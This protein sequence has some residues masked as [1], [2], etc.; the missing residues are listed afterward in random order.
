MSSILEDATLTDHDYRDAARQLF[1]AKKVEGFLPVGLHLYR[2]ADG[3]ILYARVRMH[4]PAADGGHEKLIRPFWHNGTRWTHGEP[5]QD[6][7]KL[8]YGLPDL[9]AHG[10]AVAVIVE[11]EQKADALTKIG[12]G[13]FIGITSGGATSAGGAE[14]SPLAGRHVL[15][16]P[17]HDAPGAK[18][19]DE[20]AE[21]LGEQ[22][23][24]VEQLDVPSMGLPDAGDAMDW[25]ASFK[26]ANDRMATADD[27]L[28]LP[29]IGT[30]SAG[31]SEPAIAPSSDEGTQPETDDE[32]IERLSALKPMNYDRVRKAEA[33]RMGVQVSTLDKMVAEARTDEGDAGGPFADVE[34][35]HEPVDGTALLDDLVRVVHRFIV[36]D[37]ATGHGTALWITMTWLMDSVDVAPI[38]AITAPEKRCGKSQ[39][40]FLMGRLSSRP[41]AASNITPA[42]LFRAIEA[43][44]PT[45]LIDEADAF[46]RENEELRGLLNCGHTR[47]SA[48]VVRTVG[49][50]HT[51]KQFFV[52]GAKAIAGI[53]HLAD[54]LMDR[55]ITLEL[56]RKLPHEQV[57]KLRH[58]EPGMFERLRAKLARWTDDNE[59]AIRAARPAL[60]D[61]LHDRAADNWEPLLQIAEVAGGA[62]PET[63]RRAALKLS[64][65][66]EQSQ[67]AGAELLA[68]IQEVFETHRVQ[69]I[70][71]A[72]LLT[73]L[74]NDEE[75]PW[76]TW[77]RGKPMTPRQ[78]SKKLSEYGVSSA[79]IK[80]GY[81]DV[82]KGYRADQFADAFSRYLSN[83]PLQS[84]T[85]L[86]PD[87]GAG[88]TVADSKSGSATGNANATLKPL[89]DKAGSGVADK[90]VGSHEEG[91]FAT[92]DDTEEDV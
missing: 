65:E 54:T 9:A 22:G 15:L 43:W 44:R 55:S 78:L 8:L 36:C 75:K 64:G 92:G 23:C 67:T 31:L 14:W 53:G 48:Y 13:R 59:D 58:A 68:D 91:S 86:P 17:D 85:P 26:A 5:K 30:P 45:L 79:N 81:G 47:D 87:T 10:D 34:P 1:K 69:R 70:S 3:S 61:A 60:P 2:A 74:F 63:A 24:T 66:S 51:P 56:R 32:A 40:L 77:N 41:L 57:D 83:T 35:W 76:A 25:L 82:R 62:W 12:A 6:G 20:V 42:A 80:F 21:K 11:G 19:A 37:A 18:Y 27:V 39:L 33:K 71:S 73:H 38:A 29:R 46:M 52:W 90:T 50:D 7:G 28:A 89:P 88:L 16:W 49:D 72:D 84:A 4:K